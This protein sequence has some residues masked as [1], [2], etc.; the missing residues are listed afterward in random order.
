MMTEAFTVPSEGGV[1]KML[2]AGLAAGGAA[3][4]A[5]AR[6]GA[7]GGQD[8]SKGFAMG[9]TAGSA[10]PEPSLPAGVLEVKARNEDGAP[11]AGH[12]VALGMVAKEGKL[13][14]QRVKT[15]ASGVARFENLATGE[16]HGYAAVIEW[17]GMRLGT[18]PFGMPEEGGARAEIRAFAR[19][20]DPKAV[21]IGDGAR[22]VVQLREDRLEI[23][24]MLPLENQSDKMFDPGVGAIEIPLPT[25]FVGASPGSRNNEHKLEV[26]QN[27][28]IA[29][30][31]VIPPKQAII[32]PNPRETGQEVEF[33]FVLPYD[34][35]SK[36]FVQPV[37]NGIGAFTLIT[38]QIR[39]LTV[40]GKGVGARQE[41][42]LGG[43]KYWLMPVDGVPPGGTLS[44]TLNGLPAT[45]ATG[46]GV[47]GVLVLG[48][49]ACAFAFGR[50][51]KSGKGG[52][53]GKDGGK[54]GDLDD[55][56]SRLID[57]REA[58]FT[59]LVGLEREARAGGA[60]AP[61]DRRTQLVG[62]LEQVYR[63]LA[64]L[65]EQRAV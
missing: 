61:A 39:G 49:V 52:R 2:I 36:E 65:E 23:L 59:S 8:E 25:G 60:A 22:I 3:S 57:K 26:R 7:G 20:N 40:T 46:R 18:V 11:I 21:V 47:A 15:D 54:R 45:D 37:P 41:R 1:R 42:E 14:V 53:G 56:R 10:V 27:H 43:R 9:A 29:V 64:A 62:E 17:K 31:G 35:D 24:E 48:M 50:R 51:P 19:T 16:G 44:F 33:G 32:G 38:E 58:L 63:R 4:P 28:G 6:S 34:G 55:E 12:P 30:H 13:D 5:D